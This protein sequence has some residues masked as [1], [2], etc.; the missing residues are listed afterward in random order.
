L[1]QLRGEADPITKYL[2][3]NRQDPEYKP[4]RDYIEMGNE[5]HSAKTTISIL[6]VF[7]RVGK[8]F[9]FIS[10]LM[11]IY[12]LHIDLQYHMGQTFK[13]NDTIAW[14]TAIALSVAITLVA[15]YGLRGVINQK[16]RD[17]KTAFYL[18][19]TITIV[20]S[21]TMY[22][23]HYRFGVIIAEANTKGLADK[24]LANSSTVAG[25]TASNLANNIKDLQVDLKDKRD[26]ISREKKVLSQM[27]LTT[28]QLTKQYNKYLKRKSWADKQRLK[29]VMA[30]Q[31]ANKGDILTQKNY[32]AQL[33]QQKKDIQ[34]TIKSKSSSVV[35]NISSL[36]SS[37][38]S[39]ASANAIFV[40][41]IFFAIELLGLMAILGQI[42]AVAILPQPLKDKIH[43]L[44]WNE[45]MADML[46][47]HIKDMEFQ[48]I[49]AHDMRLKQDL[50]KLKVNQAVQ[51][52]QTSTI[53]DVI[54]NNAIENKK[55]L[56]NAILIARRI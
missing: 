16:F 25:K 13:D 37:L 24:T 26:D 52:G 19:I 14:I 35:S 32:I 3:I 40:W 39:K 6:K 44:G 12:S 50:E 9:F 28:E 48:Q 20:F 23:L 7:E 29:K 15:E 36:N 31:Q 11:G 43:K 27:R 41:V 56:A 47:A 17:Y 5:V 18:I 30:Q 4:T 33:E 21:T 53:T 54:V 1:T 45:S 55:T 42:L 34:D 49:T 46:T 38:S 22:F 8:A 51:I 10:I 2:K